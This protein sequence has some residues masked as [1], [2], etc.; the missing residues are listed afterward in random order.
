MFSRCP[1]TRIFMPLTAYERII[2][3]GFQQAASDKM[4]DLHAKL[5]AFTRLL[6]CIARILP[7]SGAM[8]S[9]KNMRMNECISRMHL[10]R[11]KDFPYLNSD[12]TQRSIPRT[13]TRRLLL[14]LSFRWTSSRPLEGIYYHHEPGRK[15][16]S[17][18]LVSS[19]TEGLPTLKAGRANCTSRK[20]SS[21]MT[22]CLYILRV[23]GVK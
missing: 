18:S 10:K 15:M 3:T 4:R 17:S 12:G 22:F 5:Q 20:A 6:P 13:S 1:G 14:K 21:L 2:I 8:R 16:T 19:P 9:K 11:Q 7:N 23:M